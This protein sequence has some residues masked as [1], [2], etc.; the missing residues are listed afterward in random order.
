M[1]VSK[2]WAVSIHTNFAVSSLT[3]QNV[4]SVAFVGVVCLVMV[5]FFLYKIYSTKGGRETPVTGNSFD[6]KKECENATLELV[7]HQ[8][9]GSS[10]GFKSPLFRR[11]KSSSDK[12]SESPSSI[13]PLR[14]GYTGTIVESS[15]N[16][17]AV[18][19]LASVRRV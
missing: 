15:D 3:K 8:S 6:I 17:T 5:A 7:E 11:S 1:C 13:D 9:S 2:E 14:R 12:G 4:S 18:V 19:D 16:T 10:R